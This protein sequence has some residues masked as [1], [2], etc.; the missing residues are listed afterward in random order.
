LSDPMSSISQINF[1]QSQLHQKSV[2]RSI[3]DIERI[4]KGK[5]EKKRSNQIAF[6][7]I[8]FNHCW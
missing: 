1:S 4:L 5:K 3:I 2:K 6:T 8:A 7:Y